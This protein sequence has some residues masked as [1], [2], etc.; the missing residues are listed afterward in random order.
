MSNNVAETVKTE[1]CKLMEKLNK[2]G[3]LDGLTELEID[4]INQDIRR[5]TAN[6]LLEYQ[7]SIYN[8]TQDIYRAIVR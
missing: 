4:T 7:N 2:W 1:A 8:A 5:I 3:C 6:A